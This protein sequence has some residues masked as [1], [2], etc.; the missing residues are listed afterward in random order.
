MTLW[1][2]LFC[3]SELARYY[4]D[5]WVGALDPD[6]STAAVTFEHGLDIALEQAPA[7]IS[8]A[9]SG[10]IHALMREELRH[11]EVESP[12]R[13]GADAADPAED[14]ETPPNE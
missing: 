13:V 6:R 14:R 3:L 2:L 8:T 4:P 10:P 12:A 7:L 9:L 11:R 5:T 1:A